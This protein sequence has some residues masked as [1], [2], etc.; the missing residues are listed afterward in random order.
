M[1]QCIQKYNNLIT[2]YRE[3]KKIEEMTLII[4]NIIKLKINLNFHKEVTMRK[5]SFILKIKFIR[6]I[7]KKII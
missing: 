6:I 2:N 4:F 3:W 7:N 1:N 5:D